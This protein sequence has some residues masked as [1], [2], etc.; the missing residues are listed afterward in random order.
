MKNTALWSFALHCYARPGIQDTCLRLQRENGLDVCLLLCCC[1]LETRQVAFSAQRLESLQDSICD[2]Q[3]E[4]TQPLRQLRMAWRASAQD[5]DGL[6]DLR[7]R[8]K[9][10]ELDAERMAL[11]RLEAASQAWP[12]ERRAEAWLEH[13]LPMADDAQRLRLAAR[14]AQSGLAGF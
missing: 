3:R 1:W 12:A 11:Q 8:L 6:H 9:A 5:D 14:Q 10:L 4:I 7:E 2:W 13:Y